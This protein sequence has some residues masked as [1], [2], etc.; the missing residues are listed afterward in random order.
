M[1]AQQNTYPHTSAAGTERRTQVK[2]IKMIL[3]PVFL[4][5]TKSVRFI[6][7]RWLEI[8]ALARPVG[9]KWNRACSG[10]GGIGVGAL[11]GYS[12]PRAG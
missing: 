3:P 9:S 11:D 1:Y 8:K 6:S 10:C 7:L 2:N 12:Q 4:P 5:G